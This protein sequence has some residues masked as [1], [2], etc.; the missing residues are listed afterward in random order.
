MT[1][2]IRDVLT[3]VSPA[4]GFQAPYMPWR[5]QTLGESGRSQSGSRRPLTRPVRDSLSAS[6]RTC[7]YLRLILLWYSGLNS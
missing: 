6:G 2:D 1:L 5:R 7:V 3:Q 4:V